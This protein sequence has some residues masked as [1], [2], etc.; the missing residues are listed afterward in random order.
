M[1]LAFTANLKPAGF[2]TI[3][4]ADRARASYLRSASHGQENAKRDDVSFSVQN[5]GVTYTA[6]IGVG[7]PAT[8]CRSQVLVLVYRLINLRDRHAF[9]RHWEL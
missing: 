5:A 4:D 1:T 2:A 6:S 9:D 3:P 8:Q 7:F